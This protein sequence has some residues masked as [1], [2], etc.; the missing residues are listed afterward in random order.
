MIK[1]RLLESGVKVFINVCQ[2]EQIGESG[3]VKKLD[4]HGDEVSLFFSALPSLPAPRPFHFPCLD[5]MPPWASIHWGTE[6]FPTRR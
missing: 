1:T 6:V 3:L 4:E 2:H 5:L